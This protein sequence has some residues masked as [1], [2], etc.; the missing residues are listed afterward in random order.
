M[1]SSEIREMSDKDIREKLEDERESLARMKFQHSVATIE[2]PL[3]LKQK[4]KLV[5]RL[6]TELN[7]RKQNT[8]SES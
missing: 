8:N 2:N 4:R 1:K 7:A 5:A 3:V 6:L